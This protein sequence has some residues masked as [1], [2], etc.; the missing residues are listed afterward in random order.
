MDRQILWILLLLPELENLINSK[1]IDDVRIKVCFQAGIIHK[2]ILLFYYYFLKKIVYS[3]CDT[4]DKFAEKLDKNYGCLTETEIDKHRV[5]IN[6]ILKIDNFKDYY[7]FMGLK[8]PSE[9]EL[10]EQLKQAFENSK[11]K[12][13]HGFDEVRFVPDP[14]KQVQFYMKKY[15]KLNNLIENGKLINEEEQNWEELLDCFDI[16]KQYKY[17]FPKKLLNALELIK[18]YRE[19]INEKL[20]FEINLNRKESNNTNSEI[21]IRGGRG[22]GGFIGRRGGI[23]RYRGGHRGGGGRGGRGAPFER[24]RGR[25]ERGAP[26][27]RGRGRGERGVPF[28]RGRGRGE[29]GAPFGRGRGRGR[30]RGERGAP[31]GRGRG[32]RGASFGRG[33]GR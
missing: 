22:R 12:K 18:L 11:K 7:K 15:E 13:Y 25:G 30:G 14:E 21:G 29:R 4:L 19:K 33:R 26:F 17:T 20:F 10:N 23:R 5:E 2:Q 3:E 8:V 16:V 9:V 27:E 28:E 6:K 24:G 31:F 32:G 1:E